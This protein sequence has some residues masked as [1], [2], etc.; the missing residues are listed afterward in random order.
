MVNYRIDAFR[1]TPK[2]IQAVSL[3]PAEFFC[4]DNAY[5][6][7]EEARAR[8]P[9]KPRIVFGVYQHML[10]TAKANR[11][12]AD[13]TLHTPHGWRCGD[14]LVCTR[15]GNVKGLTQGKIYLLMCPGYWPGS[16]FVIGDDGVEFECRADRF[17]RTA[18]ASDRTLQEVEHHYAH[19]RGQ[20]TS[21]MG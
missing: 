8:V 18:Q 19:L 10:K 2:G 17:I 3:W 5:R 1:V 16:L 12:H 13:R 7:L 6:Q 9:Q 11:E 20:P 15:P 21:R 14:V 4:D